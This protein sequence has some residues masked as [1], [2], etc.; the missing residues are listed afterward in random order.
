VLIFTENI[1]TKFVVRS[2]IKKSSAQKQ[3]NQK[4]NN[5]RNA[6]ITVSIDLLKQLLSL[7][8]IIGILL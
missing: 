7:D 5:S 2:A 4:I 3:K 8:W 1:T 6:A